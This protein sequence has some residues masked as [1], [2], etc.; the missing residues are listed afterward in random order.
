MARKSITASTCYSTTCIGLNRENDTEAKCK[1]L[2]D[3]LGKG[4]KAFLLAT[5]IYRFPEYFRT[6]EV[7]VELS[8]LIDRYKKPLERVRTDAPVFFGW[9]YNEYVHDKYAHELLNDYLEGGSKDFIVHVLSTSLPFFFGNDSVIPEKRH[10]KEEVPV[11]T[12]TK[13]NTENNAA[14]EYEIED[15]VL[16]QF[17]D[18]YVIIPANYEEGTKYKKSNDYVSTEGAS[19]K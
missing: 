16:D 8:S 2:L 4:K 10:V 1:Q 7:N 9:H 12:V 3:T 19:K 11:T 18:D 5:L 6:G 15:R 14:D 17:D 13:D